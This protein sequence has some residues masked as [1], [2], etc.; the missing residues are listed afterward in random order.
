[1]Q[2]QTEDAAILF[3][4]EGEG[5][6]ENLNYGRKYI[7]AARI[8]NNEKTSISTN[9]YHTKPAYG[10]LSANQKNEK[11][12]PWVV[13]KPSQRCWE[14]QLVS[15]RIATHSPASNETRRCPDVVG[16]PDD[17]G[18]LMDLGSLKN[19]PGEP[20]ALPSLEQRKMEEFYHRTSS[21][22]LS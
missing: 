17:L 3:C 4:C 19:W 18:A 22:L 8:S 12:T 13:A 20:E 15:S 16:S 5:Y 21:N 11:Q 6:G 1:M 14:L 10:S 9:I 7:V 2:P